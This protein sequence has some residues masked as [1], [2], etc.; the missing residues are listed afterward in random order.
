MF[1]VL[2]PSLVYTDISPDITEN[3]EDH[4]ASEWSYSD[5]MVYRGALDTTFRKEGI[6]IYSLYD[7]N[8]T[9]IGLAE[10]ESENH[11]VFKT[12]WFHDT[13]YGTLLQE[14]WKE[15]GTLW[16]HITPEAYQDS[17]NTEFK[18][19]ILKGSERIILPEYVINGIPDVYESPC[20]LSFSQKACASMKKKVVNPIFIDKSFIV[21]IPP[22]DSTVWSGLTSAGLFLMASCNR[23]LAVLIFDFWSSDNLSANSVNCFSVWNTS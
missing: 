17:V 5:R 20:G 13:P 19:V 12:L 15:D 2:R 1:S 11:A 9:R 22:A 8:L 7:D 3:D 16:S 10:H 23:S 21:Y 18:D 6:D 4:D 14:D